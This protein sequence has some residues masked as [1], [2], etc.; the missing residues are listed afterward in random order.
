M[1]LPKQNERNQ[2]INILA[3]LGED[4]LA[5]LERIVGL[6]MLC[7]CYLYNEQ[8]FPEIYIY[9]IYIISSIY[10]FFFQNV[11]RVYQR[12]ATELTSLFILFLAISGTSMEIVL[13][14]S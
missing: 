7:R 13:T 6:E 1:I 5:A 10:N 4:L 2:E 12:E 11:V 9:I 14:T 3:K 8:S